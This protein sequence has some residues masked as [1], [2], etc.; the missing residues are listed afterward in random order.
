MDIE[1]TVR[2]KGEQ[3]ENNFRNGKSCAQADLLAFKEE[4]GLDEQTLLKLGAP[5]GGGMG[6]MRHVCGAVAAAFMLSGIIKSDGSKENRE[7]D[8]E[9]VRS[10]AQ[11]C[12]E[13]NGSIICAELLKG[14]KYTGGAKPEHRDE[15]YYKRRPCPALCRSVAQIAARRLLGE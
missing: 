1:E 9:L 3:A 2:I 7:R 6:R 13:E 5:F 11:D 15:E 8:Y 12:I 10:M 14:I 4:S